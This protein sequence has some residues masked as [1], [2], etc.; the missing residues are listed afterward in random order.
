MCEDQDQ[1]EGGMGEELDE[2]VQGPRKYQPLEVR[3]AEVPRLQLECGGKRGGQQPS[4]K[5]RLEAH[6]SWVRF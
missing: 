1:A 4:P 5:V 3:S 6:Y 2:G